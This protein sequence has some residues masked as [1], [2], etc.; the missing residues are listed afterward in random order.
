MDL[1]ELLARPLIFVGGKG[2]VG[3][4]TTAAALGLL[5]AR[6][7]Q[8]VL[9]VSTDPA[10]SLGDLFDTPVGRRERPLTENLHVLEIDPEVA[11]DEYI[12][13]VK[14]NLRG[15]VRPAL[16]QAVDRQMDQARL[17]PGALE[18]AM[19]ERVA[20]LMVEDTERYDRVIFDTAPTGHTLRLLEL[21]EV[22]SAWTEGMLGHQQ[23]AQHL[24][25]LLARLGSRGDDPSSMD[26]PRD[27]DQ[28]GRI[29]EILLAR[30]RL[31]YQARLRLQD[32]AAT[33]FVLVLTPE[34]LPILE[35]AKAL[36]IL[37]RFRVPVAALVVNR[38]LP[39]EADGAFLAERR[40]QEASRLA[41]IDRRFGHLD[42]WRLPLLARDI[43]GLD[44]LRAMAA[45]LAAAFGEPLDVS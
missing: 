2:G 29:R 33:A 12:D 1:G 22:M 7:G 19:L 41:E 21:P 36:K 5:A 8:R 15:L 6:R 37:A 34:R 16:Y 44:A 3:K 13:G 30:R 9:L 4:T 42:R 25:G 20:A 43:Q 31:F 28:G 26:S 32:A 27:D 39:A 10:H 14:R 18:A 23:Q 11:A 38:V 17:A 40:E 35:S 24:G 45:R